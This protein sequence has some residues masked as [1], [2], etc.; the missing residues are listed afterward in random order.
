MTRPPFDRRTGEPLYAPDDERPP[1]MSYANDLPEDRSCLALL[2]GLVLVAVALVVALLL[3]APRSAE[4]T[5]PVR[6]V[7]DAVP[8]G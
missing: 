1:A 6:P 7:R 4:T 2:I 5:A 3:A 8:L